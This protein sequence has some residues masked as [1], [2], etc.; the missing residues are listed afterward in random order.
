MTA[1]SKERTRVRER[2]LSGD[3]S[4][5]LAL[6]RRTDLGEVVIAVP[7]GVVLE[8]ELARERRVRIERERGGTVELLVAQRP[9]RGGGG[10]GVAPQQ[11][12][13]RLLRDGV[14]LPGV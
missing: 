1:P 3:R 13:R 9:D 5:Q 6:E 7:H 10:R 12:Q 8:H 14:V 2:F 11:V 4:R